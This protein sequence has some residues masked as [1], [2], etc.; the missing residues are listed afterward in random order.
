MR[1][2]DN[3]TA[4]GE[5]NAFLSNHR[6]LDVDRR[7]VDQGLSSYWVFCVDYMASGV[8]EANVDRRVGKEKVDYKEKLQPPDFTVYLALRDLRKEMSQRESV[9]VY[10][11]FTNHQLAEV[12]SQRPTTKEALGRIA[13]IGDARVQK[14]GEAVLKVLS[15]AAKGSADAPSERP[16]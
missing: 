6:V 11:L 8:A 12:A 2:R 10:T 4:E 7:W 3:G 5:L 14:Y 15:R 16:V 13:G 9:P 1:I